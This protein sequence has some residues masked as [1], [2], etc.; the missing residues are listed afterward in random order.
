MEEKAGL[1]ENTQDRTHGKEEGEL[2]CREVAE[3]ATV[4]MPFFAAAAPFFFIVAN[5]F[6]RGNKEK[7]VARARSKNM[8]KKKTWA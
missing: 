6:K 4:T 8:K 5:E 3:L 2:G 7:K 1:L